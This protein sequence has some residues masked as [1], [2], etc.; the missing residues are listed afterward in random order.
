MSPT[1]IAAAEVLSTPERSVHLEPAPLHD[2]APLDKAA[3]EAAEVTRWMVYLGIPLILA[4]AF[5]MGVLATG[6][7]WLIGGALITGPGLLIMAFVHLGLSSDT[8][9]GGPSP[10]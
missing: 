9:A 2:V 3:Q 1:S 8:N 4:A 10:H 5:F 7:L 6:Q